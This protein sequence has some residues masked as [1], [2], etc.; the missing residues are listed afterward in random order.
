[1]H[2]HDQLPPLSSFGGPRACSGCFV[3]RRATSYSH[4]GSE[5]GAS[6]GEERSI[7]NA[8]CAR[9]FER[10]P[11]VGPHAY[12]S[13]ARGATVCGMEPEA[14]SG[15]TQAVAVPAPLTYTEAMRLLRV[16]AQGG[17]APIAGP[18]R[19]LV[20]AGWLTV[21]ALD[22]QAS[23]RYRDRD[24]AVRRPRSY[25]VGLSS[26][27]RAA[28]DSA[29]RHDARWAAAGSVWA[30]L[31]PPKLAAQQAAWDR[32]AICRRMLDQGLGL[33]EIAAH[34]QTHPTRARQLVVRGA[35]DVGRPSPAE[36]YFSGA[37]RAAARSVRAFAYQ[38][39][40]VLSCILH[41]SRFLGSPR[42]VD[43]EGAALP[44][45]SES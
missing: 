28:L 10:V 2:R 25:F 18:V 38:R 20:G 30:D 32:R 14:R 4:C 33:A 3:L 39:G 27:G 22:R 40:V 15:G 24:G 6:P 34:F 44:P 23:R 41:G 5:P 26:L 19:L 29:K 37:A 45:Y 12:R 13:F 42:R 16:F 43:C 11:S 1:M 8:R 31:L 17:S 36:E 9:R 21:G 35:R 7:A